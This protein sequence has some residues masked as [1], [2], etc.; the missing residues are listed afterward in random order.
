MTAELNLAAS[1]SAREQVLNQQRRSL[2]GLKLVM[3]MPLDS[4]LE[5]EGWKNIIGDTP[6]A[7]TSASEQ[8]AL[9]Q[10]KDLR[11]SQSQIDAGQAR[12]E[13]ARAAFLPQ[14]SLVATNQW[15][16]RSAT[17]DNK[18]TSVMG[19]VSMNLFT[20]GSS[21]HQVAAARSQV[22]ESEIRLRNQE[23]MIRSEVRNAHNN[24]REALARQAIAA[25]NADKA[26]ETV[27]LVKKRY[28]EGRTILIDV[29]MA[30]RVLVE[31]RNEELASS[32]HVAVSRAALRLAESSPDQP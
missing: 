28:G 26:R 13:Q 9:T 30:E 29:L 31:T 1:E 24:L 25:E 22:N 15:Y 17:L 4:P 8:R 14:V 16:D 19:V 27:R 7:D 20:G 3:G 6:A 23:R 5:V 11:A 10:R 18:S 32:Y 12:V 2:D 21:H